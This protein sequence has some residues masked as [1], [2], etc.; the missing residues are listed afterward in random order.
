VNNR[1][2]RGLSRIINEAIDAYENFLYELQNREPRQRKKRN[3][4]KIKEFLF[5]KVF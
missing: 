1:D 5:R 4:E 3:F 2:F